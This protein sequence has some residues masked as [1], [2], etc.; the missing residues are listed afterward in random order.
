MKT[1]V[2][3]MSF[4]K[5]NKEIRFCYYFISSNGTFNTRKMSYNIIISENISERMVSCWS[6]GLND[7]ET[8]QKF[9]RPF[10]LSPVFRIIFNIT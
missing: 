8:D 3:V 7:R 5:I 4:L 1:D 10:N 2:G 9:I 6:V